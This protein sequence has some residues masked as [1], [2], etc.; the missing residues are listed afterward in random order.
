[1]AVARAMHRLRERGSRLLLVDEPSSALDATAEAAL[2]AGL[3]E[4]AREGIAVVV[5]THRPGVMAAAD[6][7]IELRSQ[8]EPADVPVGAGAGA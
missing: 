4:V 3:R 1:M 7:M 8:P 6:R 5:V 2:V